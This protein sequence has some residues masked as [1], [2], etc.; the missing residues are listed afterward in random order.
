MKQLEQEKQLVATLSVLEGENAERTRL[1]RDLHDG[2]GGML[3]VI[4]LQLCG[5]KNT[6][7]LPEADADRLAK[8]LAMLDNFIEELRRVAHNMMPESLMRYGIRESLE[9][10][11]RSIPMAS[12]Q[13]FGDNLRLDKRLEVLIY[14]CA[15]EL[16]NNAVKH[17]QATR[18][19]VQLTT[20]ERLISFT[21]RDNGTGFDPQAVQYGAGF[22]NMRNRI[23]AYNG[24]I[25]LYSAPANGTEVTIEI[26]LAS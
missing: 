23:A 12:F 21:V 13:F 7:V 17:A 19:D 3:S 25:N 4:K 1:S 10:F 6:T 9:D 14:R 18:I 2:L 26:E 20:D 5:I 8:A 24:K 22:V 15:Y 11:C 16:I